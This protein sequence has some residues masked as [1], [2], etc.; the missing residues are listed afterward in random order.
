M[1]GEGHRI[2]SEYEIWCGLS[3]LF[4]FQ[5]GYERVVVLGHQ[6]EMKT[7]V[8]PKVAAVLDHLNSNTEASEVAAAYAESTAKP[9]PNS[10]AILVLI[11][12]R[13]EATNQVKDPHPRNHTNIMQAR[14]GGGNPAG[15]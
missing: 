7:N 6:A 2:S 4:K 1:E 13:A 8:D 9:A 11:R 12:S 5:M 15:F 3:H 14:P 10:D